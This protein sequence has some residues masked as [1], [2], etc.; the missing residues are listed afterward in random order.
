MCPDNDVRWS[1]WPAVIGSRFAFVST[2][3]QQEEKAMRACKWKIF[4]AN[5]KRYVVGRPNRR[6][7]LSKFHALTG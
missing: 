3:K 7:K 6:N 5:G 2:I 4:P 1:K